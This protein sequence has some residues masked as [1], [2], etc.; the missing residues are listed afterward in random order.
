LDVEPASQA[1]RQRDQVGAAGGL[2]LVEEPQ[3]LLAG[4]QRRR[5]D[6]LGAQHR[7]LQARAGAGILDACGQA[8]QRGRLEDRVQRQLEAEVA[9]DALAP[10][11]P[12]AA[13]ASGAGSARRSSLPWALS[14]SAAS[15]TKCAG[16]M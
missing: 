15:R 9:A 4:G 1:Q 5:P 3:A 8:P 11:A 13:R 7:R 14:G 10:L 6:V 16:T 2:Q 12:S